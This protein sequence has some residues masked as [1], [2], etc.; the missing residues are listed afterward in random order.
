MDEHDFGIELE[1]MYGKE[2]FQ[3]VIKHQMRKIIS[4][5]I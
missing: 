2:V 1:K 3:S 4:E 5:S